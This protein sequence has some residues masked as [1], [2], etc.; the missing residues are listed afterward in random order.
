MIWLKTL[1]GRKTRDTHTVPGL[2]LLQDVDIF[3]IISNV[4]RFPLVNL[5]CTIILVSLK[6][7]CRSCLSVQK[8]MIYA[9]VNPNRSCSSINL[10]PYMGSTTDMS[11]VDLLSVFLY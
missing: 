2:A 10:S 11:T 6:V 4:I 7:L 5:C 3:V 1:L 8:Y 9:S